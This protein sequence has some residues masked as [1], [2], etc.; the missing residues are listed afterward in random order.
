M[1][2]KKAKSAAGHY[3]ILK[4]KIKMWDSQLEIYI[5]SGVDNLTT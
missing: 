4:I 1:F 3:G 2:L 5:S